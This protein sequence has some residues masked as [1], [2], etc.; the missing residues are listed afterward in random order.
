MSE[1]KMKGELL[2]SFI[3]RLPN[4]VEELDLNIFTDSIQ[5]NIE[6]I[7]QKILKFQNIQV[8]KLRS[9]LWSFDA[10]FSKQIVSSGIQYLELQGRNIV[11][12]FLV[13]LRLAVNDDENWENNNMKHLKLESNMSINN[14]YTEN[15]EFLE[16][17]SKLE[18]LN[19]NFGCVEDEKQRLEIHKIL[20]RVS[21]AG[22][23][24]NFSYSCFWVFGKPDQ[25]IGIFYD[26]TKHDN[27]K[28]MQDIEVKLKAK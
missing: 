15:L 24:F 17:L 26:S 23:S 21:N 19:L 25:F 13:G 27:V 11:C 12:E 8:L 16:K 14:F 28:V 4:S 10:N 20:H 22:K 2:N 3:L 7:C 1:S 6:G 5:V 18:I 9:V